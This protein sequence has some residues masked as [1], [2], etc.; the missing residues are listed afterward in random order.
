MLGAGRKQD[1][2]H[3]SGFQ[4]GAT[5]ALSTI[6]AALFLRRIARG[7]RRHLALRKTA[8]GAA[9]L[10]VARILQLASSFV[11]VPF[12]ARILTPTDFGLGRARPVCRDVL[13]LYRRRWPW[14]VAWC[15]RVPPT[16]RLWSSAHWV[17]VSLTY[18]LALVIVALLAGVDLL[19]ATRAFS[20]PVRV[21]ACADHDRTDG[22]PGVLAASAGEI[23]MAGGVGVHLG[24]CRCRCCAFACGRRR[25][26]LG[27]GLATADPAH[28]ERCRDQLRHQLSARFHS[29]V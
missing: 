17:V 23:P 7:R 22:N 21:C 4:C 26:R 13:Y 11:A 12:L 19:C 28:R 18:W 6:P 27:A 20:D 16:R 5:A 2:N 1:A 29:E 10:S 8:F 25:R 24:D 9:T 3:A 15:A 14:P